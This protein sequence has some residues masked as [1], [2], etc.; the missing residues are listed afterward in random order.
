MYVSSY[1]AYGHSLNIRR[2]Y[3]WP[4]TWQYV[5]KNNALVDRAPFIESVGSLSADLNDK[6]F[7]N[8]CD[9]LV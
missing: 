8:L 9:C 4:E 1:F 5:R 3:W 2:R 6:A 7:A